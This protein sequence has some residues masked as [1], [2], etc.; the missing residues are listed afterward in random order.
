MKPVEAFGL[1]QNFVGAGW[2]VGD[3]IIPGV[4]ADRGA[5]N[6]AQ[7]IGD[8]NRGAG[9][10]GLLLVVY[11]AENSASCGLGEARGDSQECCCQDGE[12]KTK[13]QLGI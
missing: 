4:V 1:D 5:R 11:A 13:S 6:I 9:N 3:N 12:D 10:S 8:R 2:Q 7:R